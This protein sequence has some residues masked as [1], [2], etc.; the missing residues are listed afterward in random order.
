MT[1]YHEPGGPGVR[2]DCLTGRAWCRLGHYDP[3]IAKLIVWAATREEAIARMRRALIEVLDHR[4]QTN[5]AFQLAVLDEAD[6][7]RGEYTTHFIEE[8][9]TSS[10]S[11]GSGS[12]RR[13]R[14]DRLL[15]TRPG[16]LP[17]PPASSC[18]TRRPVPLP[19]RRQPPTGAVNGTAGCPPSMSVTAVST[20]I[21]APA[22]S[23]SAT[24]SVT[25]RVFAS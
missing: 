4:D 24:V 19:E 8:Q 23:V 2:V 16:S 15:A 17:S 25:V 7:Q 18:R 5:I 12:E 21:T 1:G 22:G 10:P 14:L 11:P 20:T 6:F 3:M 13:K 9:R